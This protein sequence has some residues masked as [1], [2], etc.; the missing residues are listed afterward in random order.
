MA[1]RVFLRQ[2]ADF[3]QRNRNAWRWP[4]PMAQACPVRA[5]QAYRQT[6]MAQ[7]ALGSD[8][9]LS[10]RQNSH[11]RRFCCNQVLPT[12]SD[13]LPAF[14][15][16]SSP[17]Y[18]C[19]TSFLPPHSTIPR[20]SA[21]RNEKGCGPRKT[22][23]LSGFHWLSGLPLLSFSHEPSSF[24]FTLKTFGLPSRSVDI[25][26]RAFRS[27]VP[28]TVCHPA[29]DAGSILSGFPTAGRSTSSGRE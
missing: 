9:G 19:R 23:E 4:R 27:T 14:P 17:R 7:T 22:N 6:R 5:R 11:C 16:R 20:S 21:G 24:R 3:S 2:R 18:D 1:P 25:V 29:L 26:R 28:R 10:L 13:S 12:L 15:Y 8:R